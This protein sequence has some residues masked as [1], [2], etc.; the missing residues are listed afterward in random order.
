MVIETTTKHSF[1]DMIS[2][3]KILT[4]GTFVC[5]SHSWDTLNKIKSYSHVCAFQ[6]DLIIMSDSHVC[7]FV[8]LVIFRD[9]HCCSN[10]LLS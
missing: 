4:L 5:V 8:A 7:A 1:K 2:D 10:L 6:K 9:E 3:N